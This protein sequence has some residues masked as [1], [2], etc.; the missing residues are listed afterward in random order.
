LLYRTEEELNLW[1]GLCPIESLQQ[2]LL[3]AK[4]MD[5]ESIESM[6]QQVSEEIQDAFA[7][8][9]S[10]PF[11]EP[12]ALMKDIFSDGKSKELASLQEIPELPFNSKQAEAIPGP[13]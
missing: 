4:I 12:S 9:K 1:K 8:A 11:P 7:F 13:Y 10:S 5:G 3:E 2:T 6:E